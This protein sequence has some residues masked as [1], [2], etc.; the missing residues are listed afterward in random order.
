MSLDSGKRGL[1]HKPKA[2][3]AKKDADDQAAV[4]AAAGVLVF[5]LPED[6]FE[7]FT[8]ALAA[9]SGAAPET[10]AKSED[11]DEKKARE[12]LKTAK[13]L[14][15]TDDLRR[16][17]KLPKRKATGGKRYVLVIVR[18]GEEEPPAAKTK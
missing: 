10:G 6:K 4:A 1:I 2:T 11:V 15:A 17:L 7:T 8:R 3:T 12:Q 14:E 16:A 18:L 13:Y 5:Y 9:W